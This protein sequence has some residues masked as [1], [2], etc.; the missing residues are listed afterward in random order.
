[1][2]PVAAGFLLGSRARS[3]DRALEDAMR[4]VEVRNT[5]ASV[6]YD[7][8]AKTLHWL[9]VLL[10]VAQFIVAWTMPAIHHGTKP[11]GLIQWHLVIGS[12]LLFVVVL[13]LLWRL[14]HRPP[15]PEAGMPGWQ[16]RTAAIT[17]WALYVLLLAV[18]ITGWAAASVRPW[19]V[20]AFGVLP[21][22]LILPPGARIGFEIGDYH[23]GS[24]AWALFGVAILH[25]LAA[26]HHRLALRDRVLSRML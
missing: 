2:E 19:V 18:P 5:N 10:V 6:S 24:L 20:R 3:R 25:I 16:R 8:V 22:P 14:T 1:M 7:P 15:P 4:L 26:L 17:H 23:G 11:V 9:T 21:L 12:S 13:R